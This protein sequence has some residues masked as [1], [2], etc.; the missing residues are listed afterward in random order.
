LTGSTGPYVSPPRLG[1]KVDDVEWKISLDFGV[2]TID[3][4]GGV[5]GVGA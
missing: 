2:G 5:T 4:R 1:W 3:Y